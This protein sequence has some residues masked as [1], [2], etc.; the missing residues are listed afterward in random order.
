MIHSTSSNRQFVHGAP[1]ST[2]LH[3]T[4]LA[5]QHWQ[6]FEALR[7]T[8]RLLFVVIPATAAGRLTPDVA[9]NTNSDMVKGEVNQTI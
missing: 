1:C 9:S 6:A 2:T 5:R 3:L 8:D 4:F 7:L